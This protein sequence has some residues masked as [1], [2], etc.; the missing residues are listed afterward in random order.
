MPSALLLFVAQAIFTLALVV[1]LW[2]VLRRLL[3]GRWVAVMWGGLTFVSAQGL[4]T[5]LLLGL[6]LTSQALRLD[7]GSTGNFWFNL[8]LLSITAGLFEEVGRCVVLRFAAPGLRGWRQAVMFGAGH[9]GIEAILLVG[10]GSGVVNSI[11][12]L[13]GEV[14]L[15]TLDAASRTAL[16]QQLATLR[17]ASTGLIAAS[18]IERVFAIA[19]HISLSIL[20]MRAVELGQ[21]SWLWTAVALHTAVNAVAAAAMT[22]F[23]VLIALIAIG[24]FTSAALLGCGLAYR[25]SSAALRQT[26]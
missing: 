9:G 23:G 12:L 24:T 10:L 22:L 3:G 16:E 18:L 2:L 6:T 17:S 26:T 15:N 25:Q 13:S 8:A 1:L 14:L 5:L 7:F 20:V 4:R 11:L 21:P 19:L